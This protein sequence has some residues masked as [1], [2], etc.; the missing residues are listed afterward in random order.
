[1]IQLSHFVH[2]LPHRHGEHA[3]L[4]DDTMIVRL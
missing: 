4:F 2:V 1:M 3:R